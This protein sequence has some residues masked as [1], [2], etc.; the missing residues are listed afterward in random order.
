MQTAGTLTEQSSSDA[1]QQSETVSRFVWVGVIVGLLG[2]QIVGCM[3]ALFMATTSRSMAV[4]PDY[5]RK[6]MEWDTHKA[7]QVADAALGWKESIDVSRP[8]DI[9]ENRLITIR[10]EDTEGIPVKIDRMKTTVY[11]H[12]DAAQLHEVSMERLA[13][14]TFRGKLRIRKAGL[15][16]I[17]TQV[18]TADRTVEL[19]A[20]HLVNDGK[21]EVKKRTAR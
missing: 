13:P 19:S 9:M 2:L 14:G 21:D 12:A 1:E 16:Q 17:E 7:Q 10:I 8:I 6:A 18:T 3:F 11:H 20:K 5:H 15:W 4:I